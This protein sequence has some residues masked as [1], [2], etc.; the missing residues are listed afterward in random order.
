M[1]MFAA[2]TMIDAAGAQRAFTMDLSSR[3]KHPAIFL[4]GIEQPLVQTVQVFLILVEG[5]IRSPILKA[6]G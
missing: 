1:N 4:E 2:Q 3:Q 5:A 6:N